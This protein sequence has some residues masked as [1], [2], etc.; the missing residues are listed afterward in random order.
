M[1]RSDFEALLETRLLRELNAA[2][3]ERLE[4]WLNEHPED[5]GL[6]EDEELLS[7]ALADLPDAEVPLNFMSQVW[8]QIDAEPEVVAKPINVACWLDALRTLLPKLSWACAVL[9]LAA[10]LWRREAVRERVETAESLVPVAE[11][12]QLPSVEVLR[13]FDAIRTLG[14][15]MVGGDL[16]L[17]AVLED[18]E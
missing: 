3:T 8:R 1:D 14:E 11:V 15:P 2:E 13:D 16:E 5:R 9:V 7:G 12:A 17:L 10:V 6:W 4:R 18:L